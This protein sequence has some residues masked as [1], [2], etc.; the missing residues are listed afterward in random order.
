MKR[1]LLELATQLVAL[2]VLFLVLAVFAAFTGLTAGA[3]LSAMAPDFHLQMADR[4]GLVCRKGET[5]SIRH[6]PTTGVDSRGRPYAGTTNELYCISTAEGTTRQLTA[7][8]YL[9]A[10][11]ASI[12]VAMAGYSLLCFVPLFVPLA[13]VS[14]IL[15]H[16]VA[17]GLAKAGRSGLSRANTT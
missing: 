10:K 9:N 6:N 3:S 8:E 16:K 12:G 2:V 4:V 13:I 15:V 1:F 5:L 14:V 7:E 17:G 11:L